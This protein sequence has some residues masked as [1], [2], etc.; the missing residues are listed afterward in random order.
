MARAAAIAAAQAA[1][2]YAYVDFTARWCATC[3]VNKRVYK[4]DDVHQA[5]TAAGVVLLK[6]DWTKFRSSAARLMLPTS[7][8]R[9]K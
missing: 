4:Q 5:L 1:G 6:A 2:R 7:T 9:T 8:T 3:Q